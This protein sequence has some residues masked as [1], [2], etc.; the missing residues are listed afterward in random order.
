MSFMT[1]SSSPATTAP[2]MWNSTYTLQRNEIPEPIATSVS[3][4]GLLWITAL[5]PLIKNFWFITMIIAVSISCISP[6]AT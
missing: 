4:F 3:I 6:I 5:N 1:A 2:V